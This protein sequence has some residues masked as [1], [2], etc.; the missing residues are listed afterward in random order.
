MDLQEK[1]ILKQFKKKFKKEFDGLHHSERIIGKTPLKKDAEL[2]HI[3][4]KFCED[5]ILGAGSCSAKYKKNIGKWIVALD[6]DLDSE[7]FFAS[8]RQAIRY[9]FQN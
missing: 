5:E 9:I 7:K 2:M 6:E 8:K 1:E 3:T 4:K